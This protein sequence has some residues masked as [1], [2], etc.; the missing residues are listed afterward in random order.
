MLP[1]G[2]N[3]LLIQL[4]GKEICEAAEEFLYMQ[5]SASQPRCD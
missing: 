2:D 1:D 3:W 5:E 4:S